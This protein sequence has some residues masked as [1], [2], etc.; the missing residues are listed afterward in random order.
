MSPVGAVV[1]QV[2]LP[3]DARSL[4]SLHGFQFRTIRDS[5]TK[6]SAVRTASFIWNRGKII[7]PSILSPSNPTNT[8]THLRGPGT[9]HFRTTRPLGRVAPS[10]WIPLTDASNPARR[11][12]RTICLWTSWRGHVFPIVL[13]YLSCVLKDGSG[14]GVLFILWKFFGELI[15]LNRVE[16]NHS[17]LCLRACRSWRRAECSGNPSPWMRHPSLRARLLHLGGMHQWI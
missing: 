7:T 8:R 9:F 4:L 13:S 3:T 15:F 10:A 5:V 6:S 12:R 17:F 14:G 11:T 16:T 2:V 1:C